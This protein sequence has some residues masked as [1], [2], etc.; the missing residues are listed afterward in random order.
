MSSQF[1]KTT[2]FVQ[3][4]A[5]Q[6]FHND[7]IAN[8]IYNTIL[9]EC[10]DKNDILMDLTEINDSVIISIVSSKIQ[11]QNKNIKWKHDSKTT[12][13]QLLKTIYNTNTTEFNK[14]N[15]KQFINPLLKHAKK[16][17]AI[18]DTFTPQIISITTQ[19]NATI[20]RQKPININNVKELFNENADLN[21]STILNIKPQ[22]FSQ[23]AQQYGI[24]KLQSKK[25]LLKIQS[26]FTNDKQ[27]KKQTLQSESTDPREAWKVGSKCHIHS[28]GKKKWFDGV[29]MDI[30]HDE[31]GEWLKVGYNTDNTAKHKEIQRY[32]KDIKPIIPKP[33]HKS[34]PKPIT[35]NTPLEDIKEDEDEQ[36]EYPDTFST[37]KKTHKKTISFSND[38]ESYN[39]HTTTPRLNKRKTM[40]LHNYYMRQQSVPLHA[41]NE[42]QQP[43]QKQIWASRRS[44]SKL[45]LYDN[46]NKSHSSSNF[47]FWDAKSNYS[48]TNILNDISTIQDEYSWKNGD[49]CQTYIRATGEWVDAKIVHEFTHENDKWLQIK[50]FD[51]NRE[52]ELAANDENIR[53]VNNTSIVGLPFMGIERKARSLSINSTLINNNDERTMTS[54]L[55]TLTQ[56]VDV[57]NHEIDSSHNF[58]YQVY[59]IDTDDEWKTKT[60]ITYEHDKAMEYFKETIN[61]KYSTSM[62]CNGRVLK[63]YG[64]GDYYTISTAT[65]QSDY[66]TIH[67]ALHSEKLDKEEIINKW[68]ENSYKYN[69]KWLLSVSK[70]EFVAD[71]IDQFNNDIVQN[72]IRVYDK[73]IAT[74]KFGAK[75]LK[76]QDKE[77]C[78]DLMFLWTKKDMDENQHVKVL[79]HNHFL[80]V[81]S[82]ILDDLKIEFPE[83]ETKQILLCLHR[84]EMNGLLFSKIKKNAFTGSVIIYSHSFKKV[85]INALKQLVE[86]TDKLYDEINNFNLESIKP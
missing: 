45:K 3:K 85:E 34:N 20:M 2:Q 73:L 26:A 81:V 66:D 40:P 49:I 8:I 22:Q 30:F 1:Q 86:C 84:I 76:K 41:I 62:L 16:S 48:H 9:E 12:L 35:P 36:N 50:C 67:Q 27:L 38:I 70:E 80:Y 60:F 32:N 55:H 47:S 56:V 61:K 53:S 37:N 29:I 83:I 39:P 7:E 25:L 11:L 42:Q 69:R 78:H 46:H 82:L 54:L 74:L 52:L 63:E 77:H 5:E 71:F 33:K 44:K 23:K 13:F 64:L 72:A 75:E 51:S 15:I 79:D 31:Q 17:Y 28:N 24:K 59:Y 4:V 19:L 21:E 43:E 68:E 18:L 6:V 14:F 58:L 57:I 10:E 65:A